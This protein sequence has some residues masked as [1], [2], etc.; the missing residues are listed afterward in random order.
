M[1]TN[2]QYLNLDNPKNLESVYNVLFDEVDQEQRNERIE[3][4]ID[5]DAEDVPPESREGNSNTEGSDRECIFIRESLYY[6]G[7]E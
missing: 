2:S 3:K 6:L 5:T 7:K 4:E 1:A